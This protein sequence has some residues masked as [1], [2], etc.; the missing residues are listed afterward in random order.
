MTTWYQQWFNS[1]Y[2][3]KLYFTR[4]EIEARDFV[5]RLL[6]FLKPAPSSR[7]IDVGCGRGRHAKMLAAAG[8]DVTGTDL[9]PENI[10]VAQQAETDNLHFYQHDMRLPFWVSFFDY[11]FNF[12]TSFGYF[13]TQREHDAALRSI[14]NSLKPKGCFV[15]DYLNVHY[16]EDHLVPNEV[17]TI[18]S[19][20]FDIHRWQDAG[21]FYKRIRIQDVALD[22]PQEFTEKIAKFG[23]GDFT[24]ML[25]Y[26]GLQVTDVFGDYNLNRFDMRSTPRLILVAKK[27]V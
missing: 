15:I 4:D 23:L 2:Y 21:H 12:F 1:P 13:A 22:K 8:F 7:M 26:Q 18:E 27:G 5:N 16:A 14:A 6:T 10:A 9:S 25:A 17:K 3:H 11:A 24:N 19:T 20:T